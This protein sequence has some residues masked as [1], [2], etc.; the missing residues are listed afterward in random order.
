[1]LYHF[2]IVALVLFPVITITGYAF[3]YLDEND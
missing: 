3:I 2:T 1:M